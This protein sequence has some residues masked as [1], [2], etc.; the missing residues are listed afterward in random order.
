MTF[1]P[2][3]LNKIPPLVYEVQSG[4][5]SKYNSDLLHQP[6]LSD[7]LVCQLF[8]RV[9]TKLEEAAFSFHAPHV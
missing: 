8:P 4:L 6:D 3:L 1:L 2:L 9:K 7:H 5:S